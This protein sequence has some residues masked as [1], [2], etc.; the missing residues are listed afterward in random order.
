MKRFSCG[1][2]MP[3]CT[4]QFTSETRLGIFEQ[5]AAHAVTAHGM[6]ELPQD[7]AAQV[8]RNISE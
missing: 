4:A 2:V 6:A 7:L 5:V 3:H 1:S 8:L